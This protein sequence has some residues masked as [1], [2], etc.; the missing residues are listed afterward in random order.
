MQPQI[1]LHKLTQPAVMEK[2]SSPGR[3]KQRARN[4]SPVTKRDNREREESPKKQPEREDD[5]E[6]THIPGS[7]SQ[8]PED[9][10]KEESDP[11]NKT[12]G[13]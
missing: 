9:S 2:T 1:T 8:N 10:A 5:Q 13:L 4:T 11:E 3:Q 6:I 7:Q 12:Q